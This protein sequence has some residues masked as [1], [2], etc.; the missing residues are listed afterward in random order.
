MRHGK[1]RERGA[2]L[3]IALL[4]ITI[5]SFLGG[6]LLL[7]S[8]GETRVSSNMRQATIAFTSA[9]AGLETI[10]N[11]W[12]LKTA[13]TCTPLTAGCDNLSFFSGRG[14]TMGDTAGLPTFPPAPP[15]PCA[16][17][18]NLANGVDC[19]GLLIYSTGVSTSFLLFVNQMAELETLQVG[20]VPVCE[21]YGC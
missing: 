18:F 8:Q 2:A 4:V 1:A 16:P 21:Q 17:G 6:I 9:E 7:M 11:Q 15:Q 12:P 5:L 20:V 14:K 10:L 3:I 19:P 13:V